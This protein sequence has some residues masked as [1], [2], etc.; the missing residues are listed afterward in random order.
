MIFRALSERL[1]TRFEE[2]GLN[3]MEF[4]FEF[5]A[6]TDV[7]LSGR[8]AEKNNNNIDTASLYRTAKTFLQTI[9]EAQ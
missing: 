8:N 6:R 3:V 5:S 7:N 9:G 4:N 1:M 2:N